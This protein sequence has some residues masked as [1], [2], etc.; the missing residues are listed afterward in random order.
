MRNICSIFSNYK[1]IKILV[2]LLKEDKNVSELIKKCGLSQSAV[3][4]H[5]KKLRGLGVVVCHTDG[6]NKVY[7]LKNKKIGDIAQRIQRLFLK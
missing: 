3:S 2:C 5:L 6:R 7:R 1:R 4:Q